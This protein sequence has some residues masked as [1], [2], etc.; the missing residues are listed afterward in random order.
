MLSWVLPSW[1]TPCFL[2]VYPLTAMILVYLST[3]QLEVKI[4]LNTA[5]VNSV[6]CIQGACGHGSRNCVTLSKAARC[7]IKPI[8]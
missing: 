1:P 8:R 2:G 4:P 6:V 7:V 5:L 3:Q